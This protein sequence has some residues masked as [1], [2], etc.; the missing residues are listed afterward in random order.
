MPPGEIIAELLEERCLSQ[1]ELA[2]R[3]GRPQKTINEIIHGKAA[4][5]P[6]TAYQLEMV[7]GTPASYWLTHE[8]H[9]RAY[10]HAVPRRR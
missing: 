9:Y 7:L 8:A 6:E 4:L 10:L 2:R 1:K 5:T 3:M